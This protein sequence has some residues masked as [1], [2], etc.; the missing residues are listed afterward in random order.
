MIQSVK[1]QAMREGVKNNATMP[2]L[3][4]WMCGRARHFIHLEDIALKTI[5]FEVHNKYSRDVYNGNSY[6]EV[7]SSEEKASTQNCNP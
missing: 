2:G 1:L 5:E 7:E 3:T 4:H 6:M